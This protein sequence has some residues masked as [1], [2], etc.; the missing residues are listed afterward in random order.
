MDPEGFVF[1][2]YI[3]AEEKRRIEK[4]AEKDKQQL[5][6][7]YDKWCM[8]HRIPP[9]P[10]SNTTQR[11]QSTDQGSVWLG[12]IIIGIVVIVFLWLIAR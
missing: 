9:P 8:D 10:S 11:Y 6:A 4:Q 1:G 5:K 12:P 7:D 3:A 2:A